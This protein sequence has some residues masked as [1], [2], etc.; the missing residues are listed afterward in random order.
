MAKKKTTVSKKKTAKSAQ[1][2]TGGSKL[3]RTE[4]VQ[5][6]LDPKLRFAAELA[7]RKHRRTLSAFIEWAVN[8]SVKKV[9]IHEDENGVQTTIDALEQVW[10]VDK[11]DR[12][13]KLC[14]HLPHLLTHEEEV[15]W[16]LIRENSYRW[17][18]PGSLVLAEE[19]LLGNL[20]E[21][22]FIRFRSV[23]DDFQKAARKEIK[24][25]DLPLLKQTESLFSDDFFPKKRR[26][27]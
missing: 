27:K 21:L 12:F 16:K 11:A 2:K 24:E 25:K 4:I 9:V 14:Q 19:G 7:A 15:L 10:D 20:N 6:R 26:G 13:I 5:V 18:S 22:D 1:R 17:L 8:E 23:W 3:V